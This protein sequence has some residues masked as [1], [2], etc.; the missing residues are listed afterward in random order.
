MT[1]R[2]LRVLA[3][4]LLLITAPGVQAQEL[5][6]AVRLEHLSAD[7]VLAIAG[8]L[9][10]GGRYDE[11]QALLDRLAQDSAGGTE[12]DFLD[13][14]I[15]L[16]RKD[17]RRAEA[18]FRRILAGDPALVRV[19]L[20]LARTL[21][22]A[23]KDEEADYHFRLAIAERPPEAVIRNIARFREGIRARRAWRF[24]ISFGLAPD[25]NINSATDKES[26]FC[27]VDS[28]VKRR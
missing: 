22:L 27:V 3:W 25:T 2:A 4:P 6:P 23:K 24:N 11:A 10:D 13:G 9:I 7:D 28:P 12:R 18:L 5:P 17:Y 20:E 19:R 16:A 26:R 21:F 15:A 8:R 1:G 14:M